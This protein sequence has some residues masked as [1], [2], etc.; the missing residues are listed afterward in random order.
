MPPRPFLVVSHEAPGVRMSGPAIRCWHLACALAAEVPVILAVPVD[1]AR[2]DALAASAPPLRLAAFDWITGAGLA[3][4]L[5]EAGALLVSGFALR[6]YPALAQAA[7]PLVVDLY[8]PFLLENLEIHAASLV[9]DQAAR[10]RLDLAVLDEQLRRGDFFL[11]A[12]ETQ[13]D[14]WLG[15]L[16][17]AERVN[18]LNFQAD[19]SL[20]RLIA[21]LPFG[22]PDEAPVARRAALK[23]VWPGIAAGDQVVYWGGGIWEWFDPLTAIRAVAALARRRPGLRLFFAGV[24]HPNPAVP[25]MRQVAAAQ[26]ESAALGL[27]GQHVFFN[28]DWVPYHERA[29]YLLDADLGISLHFDHIETRFAYRTRLLDYLWAG[30][31][32]VLS[33]GDALSA[34]LAARGLAL[35]TAP[36]DVTGVAAAVE[37]WL[38]E[39]PDQRQRRQEQV[40]AVAHAWRWSQVVT[41]LVEF[42]RQPVFAPDRGASGRRPSLEPGLLAK[43]WQS[44]RARGPAGLLRDIR[45]YLDV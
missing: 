34:E 30:L 8:D 13:R 25:A 11:C 20:R 37:A 5:A 39:T 23:G 16:A 43:A 22:L 2:A 38:D 44:L 14:F 33:A 41:P 9:P 12:S 3:A 6:H 29:D 36:G 31:P 35:V 32:M 42:A 28:E 17:A 4:P 18:P 27:T 15:M 40:R 26:A 21:V 1:A 45:L 24:R 19:P 10:H 7:A